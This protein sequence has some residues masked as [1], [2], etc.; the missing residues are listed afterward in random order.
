MR[1]KF[2]ELFLNTVATFPDPE[3]VQFALS[4]PFPAN[5]TKARVANAGAEPVMLSWLSMVL[6][7]L[8]GE[9]R[10]SVVPVPVVHVELDC[11]PK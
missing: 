5:F 11:S 6:F 10:L 3:I 4:E 1:V 9:M 8:A 2:P 7:N